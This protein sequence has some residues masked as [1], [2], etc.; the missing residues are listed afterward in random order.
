MHSPQAVS[1]R[2]ETVVIPT[3]EVFPAE[4]AP[5]FIEKRAYQGSSGKI[6]PLPVVEKIADIKH[7]RPYEALILENEYLEATILPQI[8]GKIHRAYDKTN[9]Y[10]FIYHNHVI[11]PA[12]VG[13]A[14]P[15]VSG[16]IEF[17]WPQHHRPTTFATVDHRTETHS[18]G[19]CSV[20][21]GETDP[22]YGTKGMA[23]ITLYPGKAYI[24]ISGRLY[25]PTAFAQTF[26]WWANPA[27][28]VNDYTYSVMPPDVN[29]VM[30]HGKRAVS[31]FPIATGEYYK[32]DYSAGVDISRYKNI[33]VPT[34]YMA[35]SSA[36][37]FIGNYDERIG[38]GLLHVADHHIAPGKKQWTWGNAD[39][40]RTWDN[41]L[42]DADGP[43]IE[44]MT[45]VYTDNQPDFTW[46][47]P[48]EEKTFTQVFMP[49]HGVGRV[50]NAT[51][52]AAIGVRQTD[53]GIEVKVYATAEHPQA[54]LI[55]TDETGRTYEKAAALSPASFCTAVFE[56][57]KL[58][59]GMTL[60]VAD[61]DTLCV[62]RHQAP[63][64]KPIPE[65]AKALP[66]PQALKSTEELYLAAL[67]LEQYRHATR[68]P[69]EYYEEGLRRDPSDIRLNNGYGL[70]LL[71]RGLIAQSLPYFRA[72][73]D[74]QTWKNPNPYH[75]ECYF[76]LGLALMKTGDA[77]GAYDA[78]YKSS[79]S[80]ETQ[81]AGYYFL[82][83]L[84]VQKG[85]PQKALAF[86]EQS[87]IRNWH[88]MNART[89]KAALLRARPAEQAAWLAQSEAIDPLCMGIQ[90]EKALAAAA[91]EP[92]LTLMRE[93]AF[94]YIELALLYMQLGFPQ[95]AAQI[96]TAC[97]SAHPIVYYLLG[98][99]ARDPLPWLQKAEHM[100]IDG[101]NPSRLEEMTALS[102]AAEALPA[103]P[104]AHY[105]LGN[106]YYDKKQ[107]SLAVSHWE[108]ALAQQPDFPMCLR[109]LSIAAYN[110]L[111]DASRAVSLMNKACA[112][113]PEYP[114][115]W[116]E[117]DQLLVKTACPVQER[118]L[119]LQAH[120]AQVFQRDDL[121]LR[122][123]TLYNCTGNYQTALELLHSHTFHPWEGGEGKVSAQYKLALTELGKQAILDGQYAQAIDQLQQTLAY[124]PNLGEGKLPNAS[125]HQAHYWMGVAYR[126]MKNTAKA[127]ECFLLAAQ[128]DS[129]PQSALYYNDL[130]SDFI[131]YQGLSHRALGR[132]NAAKK[133]FYQLIAFGERHL[134][135]SV[136][137]DYFAVS[138]PEIEVYQDD[139]PWNNRQYC[140]YLRALGELGIGHTQKADQLLDTILQAQP[141][142][143]GA[144]IH[145]RHTAWEV[146]L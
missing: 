129:T 79:W 135:D 3:Y 109:N 83:C 122:L 104:H 102:Y 34:S 90:Y 124:P 146:C 36:Y 38:A 110:K 94:N 18:D 69:K 43:Y 141:D 19:S 71:K 12:L 125:D 136:S 95:D 40:G 82:A 14:G 53:T 11:K 21:V 120:E 5:L 63:P 78:F 16:G 99:L 29:A 144:L 72:A 15:W 126:C 22:M 123:I 74:K 32:Y 61:G 96:L 121:T 46:L 52:D 91:F 118:L 75:G 17:N 108:T 106:L 133:C 55:L 62:Y 51:R 10:D 84:S 54:A 24:E 73:V 41:N 56:G 145:R 105:Y 9:G 88:D 119:A 81:S 67:H 33:K 39:F 25:N 80:A 139:L 68:D 6:Y 97:P 142:H 76:N 30:D 86:A 100:P 58:T 132:E 93:P 87:L 28:A 117:R 60:R 1:V 50:C 137:Y 103:A 107:Y 47:K 44:L 57:L 20:Y 101:C 131:Y 45:G 130:P 143:Q 92:F 23:K 27:V 113:L 98:Y 116:L 48:H 85:E 115:F 111:E 8:G 65:P 7:D 114:R 127:E 26:L 112:L 140:T 64:L 89:L 35:A 4:K 42:T 49:Y 59:D 70:L 134:F 128:G 77:D 13:L 138:L 66:A 37:D 2:R 31:T